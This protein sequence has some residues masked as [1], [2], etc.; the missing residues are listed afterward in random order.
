MRISKIVALGALVIVA[1]GTAARALPFTVS[2]TASGF[3]AGAPADPVSGSFVYEAASITGPILTLDAINLTIAGFT[4]S[5]ANVSFNASAPTD[6]TIGGTVNGVS[7]VGSGTNDFFLQ[8]NG[9]T[10]TPIDF[11]YATP[12][13]SQGTSFTD[14]V[15]RFAISPIATPEPATLALLGTGLAAL[16]LNR[17]RRRKSA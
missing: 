13:D 8:F 17:M 5:L 14:T 16:G 10:A 6:E 2:F 3:G 4:Y 15:S 11:G 12:N 1:S 9:V 7:V